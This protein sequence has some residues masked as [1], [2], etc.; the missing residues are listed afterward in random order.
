M[1]HR[2]LQSDSA[3]YIVE[4]SGLVANVVFG[5][6][7]FN[8]L[9]IRT[10]I[11]NNVAFELSVTAVGIIGDFIGPKNKVVVG[12]LAANVEFEDWTIFFLRYGAYIHL[13]A[14]F[15]R[16]WRR[17][18]EQL[19]RSDGWK[20]EKSTE[21]RSRWMVPAPD[22]SSGSRTPGHDRPCYSVRQRRS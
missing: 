11:D 13:I 14:M 2:F 12:N 10:A 15:N 1:T 21:Y 16:R 3:D 5:L 6:A 17:R 9:V 4:L 8:V 19:R 7:G 22:A 20:N 18:T